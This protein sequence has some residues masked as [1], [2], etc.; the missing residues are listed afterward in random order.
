MAKFREYED[1]PVELKFAPNVN[2]SIFVANRAAWHKQCH[3]KKF[4]NSK[5]D[6]VLARKRKADHDECEVYQ[7]KS[8]RKR[9]D[10]SNTFVRKLTDANSSKLEF[11]KL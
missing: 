1:M 11:N 5:L 8:K 7:R 6:R 10:T 2:P 3:T 9:E 4:Y